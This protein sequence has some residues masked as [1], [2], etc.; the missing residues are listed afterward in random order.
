ME[1]AAREAAERKS[2]IIGVAGLAVSALGLATGAYFYFYPRTIEKPTAQNAPA[3]TQQIKKII[4]MSPTEKLFPGSPFML[5]NNDEERIV[6]ENK[7]SAI[8]NFRK[9]RSL[10]EY[11]EKLKRAA[12]KISYA[13]TYL[14]P[15]PRSACL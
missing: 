2:K 13:P 6:P 4:P 3:Q 15:L 14:Y 5:K 8:D 7:Q 1:K 12:A 10:A 11:K 9:V